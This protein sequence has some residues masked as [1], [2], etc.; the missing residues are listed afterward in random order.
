MLACNDK[1]FA[2]MTKPDA[3]LSLFSKHMFFLK[4]QVVSLSSAK[5]RILEIIYLFM[6]Q[7]FLGE[8]FEI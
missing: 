6:S 4:Y 8:K 5:T 1:A 7:S 3:N 2:K